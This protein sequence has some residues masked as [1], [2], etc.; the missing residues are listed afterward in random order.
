MKAFDLKQ[1]IAEMLKIKSTVSTELR[2]LESKRQKLQ[3]DISSY[4]AKIDEL[5][6][7]LSRQ[8]TELNRLKISV[9]QA[10][11][12]QREAILRNT[13]ELALPKSIFPNSLMKANK[14]ISFSESEICKM[15]TCFDHSRCS[16]TS[17][18]PVY[19][20]D[21]DVFHVNNQ[22][23]EIDGFLK[24]TIKQTF[25]FNTHV[26]DDPK[27]ACIFVVLVGEA[28]Q[29]T[30]RNN[31][32][33]NSI[34]DKSIISNN[35][36]LNVTALQKL[37][38]WSG[39]GRNHVLMNFARRELSTGSRNVF[40][41]VNTGRAML[42]QSTFTERQYR[43]GFDVIVPPILGKPG[44]DVWQECSS[45]LPARRNYLLSFQGETM[46]I[47]KT[48]EEDSQDKQDKTI[49]DF[50]IDHLREISNSEHADKLFLQFECI[51]ATEQSNVAG[52]KDW[53]LCGTDN[54]RR[55]VLRDSTFS[56]ILVP[57][58]TMISTTLMQA[59][60]YESLRSGSIPVFLGG[61]Q[62]ELPFAEMIEWRKAAVIL[63]KARVTEL[64][65]LLRSVPDVDLLL[66]RRQGRMIWERYLSSVQATIDTLLAYIR[67]R[68][69]IPPKP[70]PGVKSISVFNSTFIPLKS[71]PP[72]MDVEPEG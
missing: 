47:N 37:K 23:Y 43:H 69:G 64:H 15:S 62:V 7:E 57:E 2:D 26:T 20:Y 25:G 71:D 46:T 54:S 16:I 72:V 14:P 59:R 10:Q 30:L 19:L 3:S 34:D 60:L 28:L 11:V 35:E 41:N 24:T 12:A 65:F 5:K 45:M 18:F 63:P 68:L 22:G 4:N 48:R 1:R 67:D 6:Q 50:I 66:M 33:A 9:E 42:V 32:Y 21:P 40:A 70:V 29:E 8:Q 51:P 36:V 49:D 44:G 38:Y 55:A 17:N 53:Y 27:I 31:R 56:L 61:D 39:D 13:P 58:K 52:V